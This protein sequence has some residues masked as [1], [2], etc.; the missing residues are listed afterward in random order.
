VRE[1][2]AMAHARALHDWDLASWT[3]ASMANCWR[4]EGAAVIQPA[5]IN[6]MRASARKP[7]RPVVEVRD[8]KSFFSVK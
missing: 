3:V 4:G 2:V 8:L 5:D 6:P 1:L 7:V